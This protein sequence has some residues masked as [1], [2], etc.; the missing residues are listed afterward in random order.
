MKIVMTL[1]C[2]WFLF[3]CQAQEKSYA[4]DFPADSKEKAAEIIANNQI[5]SVLGHYEKSIAAVSA[6]FID[7]PYHANTLKGSAHTPEILVAN[8]SQVDCFTLLDYTV[9]LS[10]ANTIGTFINNLVRV[11]YINSQVGYLNRR[12]FF[13]DWAYRQPQNA[14]DVTREISP[15]AI[16]VSKRLNLNPQGGEYIVGLGIITRD[17]DYIPSVSINQQVLDNLRTGDY[18]GIYSPLEGLDVS[19]TGIII[20]KDGK[21]WFRNASSLRAN[22][23]VVD[24]LFTDYIASR[25]GILV[26][27]GGH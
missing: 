15:D 13:T 23:K 16:R 26:L 10:G 14:R 2:S 20:R 9:A 18:I 17:I 7:T 25:P 19:H 22:M 24:A 1:L 5:N 4:I 6:A 27:R 11:R 21:I 12:H 3:A 8:L